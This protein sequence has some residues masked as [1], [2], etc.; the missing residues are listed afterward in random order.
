MAVKV[1]F[2]M[3]PSSAARIAYKRPK[4]THPGR[5]RNRGTRDSYVCACMVP[6]AAPVVC[7]TRRPGK[8]EQ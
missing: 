3:F 2:S 1:Q 7:C 6:M 4:P 5:P 8:V